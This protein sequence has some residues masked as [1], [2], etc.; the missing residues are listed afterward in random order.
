MFSTRQPYESLPNGP[1]LDA[2][3]TWAD[4]YSRS[5]RIES[6]KKVD[7]YFADTECGP[8][9]MIAIQHSQH[10]ELTLAQ[11]FIEERLSA[12]PY[13]IFAI[14]V[15]R[16][17]CY[18]CNMWLDIAND[19]LR[20]SDKKVAVRTM[21]GQRIDGWIQTAVHMVVCHGHHGPRN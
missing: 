14:G 10:A 18:W 13:G 9:G 1:V 8:E 4:H 19:Q 20:S 3:N 12:G 16:G 2:L 15:S 6:F 7:K 17:T 11:H 21:T 5:E